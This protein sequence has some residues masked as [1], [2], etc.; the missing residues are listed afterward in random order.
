MLG[1]GSLT[2]RRYR[3]LNLTPEQKSKLQSRIELLHNNWTI[4]RPYIARPPRVIS[5]VSVDPKLIV[6]PPRGLEAGY[7][8][9]VTKQELA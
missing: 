5:L 8:P 4:D 1:I 6:T 3:I 7:V 9:I 2:S